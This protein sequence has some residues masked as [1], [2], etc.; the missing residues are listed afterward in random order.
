MGT[1]TKARAL[2]HATFKAREAASLGILQ[3]SVTKM[4]AATATPASHS[5][6]SPHFFHIPV[7]G[8]GF[9]ID[10]PLKVARYGITSTVSLLD[11]VLIE[12]MREHHCKQEGVEFTPI[13]Q[14]AADYRAQRITAY[15]NLLDELVQR[16]VAALRA[17]PF[18]P[19]TDITRYFELLPEGP[20]RQAYNIM[21]IT[22]DPDLRRQT[23]DMLRQQITA[24][25]IDVNIMTRADGDAY[26][27]GKQLP[28]D[29]TVAISALRGFALSNLRSAVVFSAGMNQRLYAYAAEF[30]DFLPDNEGKLRKHIILKVSDFRSALIQGKFL[31]RQGLWVSEFRV[32]SGINCGGH[33]FSGKGHLMG[34]VLSEFRLRRDEL[35][36]TLYELQCKSLG[37]QGRPVPAAPLEMRITAQG[38]IGT[39]G[40]Q[41]ELMRD[42]ELDGTGWGTPFLLVPEVTNVDTEHL[43]RLCAARDRDVYLSDSSP[44]GVP[45]WN[46]R[47][48]ASETARRRRIAAGR[49]GSPCPKGYGK[50]NT[51]FTETAIC[52][53]SRAYQRLKLEQLASQHLSKRQMTHQR[54]AVT[55]KSCICH[56]L[57]GCAT[58]KCGIDPKAWPAMCCG[59]AIASYTR[60]TTLD[61]MA[62]HI[63]GR[64]P[65]PGRKRSNHMFT[66]ELLLNIAVLRQN[67]LKLARGLWAGKPRHL[68]EIKANLVQQIAE[69]RKMLKDSVGQKSSRYLRDLDAASHAIQRIPLAAAIRR[70]TKRR[71]PATTGNS[72]T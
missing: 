54:D 27:A 40:E 4:K 67:V 5:A 12:Q 20:L 13:D 11:D 61:E 29:Q 23:Q 28:A 33:A 70:W 39:A 50:I 6:R 25:N 18:R 59:P 51:E 43:R 60:I 52:T 24:G 31:A 53:A 37:Q 68:Q 2:V 55:A 26:V 14:S 44:L 9:T 30:A 22:A 10:T 46:L 19:N 1:S 41:K 57:A 16:Q 49:P 69:Y 21:Q 47:G 66:R 72:K 32:E 8:T 35:R 3:T 42:Y 63:Y 36:Q 56:D 45:F 7:M 48:S 58:L 34:F 62:N 64:H 17:Q 38:G 65:L 71:R 15:L